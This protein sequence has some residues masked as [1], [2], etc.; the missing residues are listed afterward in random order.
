MNTAIAFENLDI[1]QR[2]PAASE[3]RIMVTRTPECQGGGWGK[4]N[5][6][7]ADEVKPAPAK[8]P[9]YGGYHD[10]QAATTFQGDGD[11]SG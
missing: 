8:A 9:D 6:V 4:W 1:V 11:T 7:L 3:G 10:A 5:T 2:F